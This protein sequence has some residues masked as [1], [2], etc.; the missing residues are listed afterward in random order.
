M[1]MQAIVVYLGCA[2][3]KLGHKLKGACAL[4]KTT[5]S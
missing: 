3:A 5:D 2:M 1:L 4:P